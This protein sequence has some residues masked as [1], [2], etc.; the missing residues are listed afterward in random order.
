M[1]AAKPTLAS[2]FTS[3]VLV[4]LEGCRSGSA[5]LRAFMPAMML[6]RTVLA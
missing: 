2:A 6:S 3:L 4:R 1:L 5:A